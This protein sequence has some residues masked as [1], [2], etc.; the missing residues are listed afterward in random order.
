MDVS[1][2]C[3]IYHTQL[4]TIGSFENLSNCDFVHLFCKKLTK[5]EAYG[6][7]YGDL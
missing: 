1:N 2:Y 5:V 4:P 3:D 6:D 7:G